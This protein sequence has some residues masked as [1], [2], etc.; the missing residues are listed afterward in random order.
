MNVDYDG[1]DTYIRQL[2]DAAL[3]HVFHATHRSREELAEMADGKDFPVQLRLAALQLAA[4]WYR[5]REVVSSTSQ[6]AVPYTYDC[7]IK[8]F[9]KL[10]V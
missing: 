7:L 1:D 4:H 10:G 6:N 8:P 5:L 3:S 9:V 2:G